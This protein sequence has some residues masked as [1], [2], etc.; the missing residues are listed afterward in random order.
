[1]A[2]LDGLFDLRPGERERVAGLFALSLALGLGLAVIEVAVDTAL[3]AGTSVAELPWAH[4]AVAVAVALGG[5]LLAALRACLPAAVF[6]GGPLALVG[7]GGLVFVLHLGEALDVVT[8]LALYAGH[9]VLVAFT[10]V[11]FWSLA[12]RVLDV[13]QSRRLYGLVS[14][15]EL[16]AVLVVGLVAAPLQRAVDLPGQ[17]AWAL[18]LLVLGGLALV[19]WSTRAGWNVPSAM[20]STP[21][22]SPA[23]TAVERRHV[24]HLVRYY[25]AYNVT[26]YLIEFTL[27]AA[28][29]A[30]H[31]GR[32]DAIAGT[33]GALA[34][35]RISVSALVRLLLTGRLLARVGLG[36][37]L[38]S[39]PAV[40][41]AMTGVALALPPLAA[42]IALSTGEAAA[43]GAV[44]KPA[45]MAAQRPLPPAPRERLLVAVETVAEPA[46]TAL[47][48]AILL[49]LP[50]TWL[51]GPYLVFLPTPIAALW[52]LAAGALARSYRRLA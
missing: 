20:S 41:L 43:R 32:P 42:T 44:G 45:F 17:L 31:P 21:V 15:G 50:G 4:V 48:G 36:V 39:T 40:V 14:G 7:I 46:T 9:R 5:G 38:A 22:A 12:A 49:V 26:F 47:A 52:L 11:A 2:S 51:S 3:L 10:V 13:E 34:I 6:L 27:F 28:V 23:M 24:A 33:L 8:L 35:A 16:V 19:G 18:G 37:G 30:A 1:M 25:A 29:Q